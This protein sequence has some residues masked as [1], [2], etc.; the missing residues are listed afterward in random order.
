[1]IQERTDWPRLPQNPDGLWQWC[2]EQDLNTL[3]TLLAYCAARTVNAIKSKTNIDGSDRLNHSN[4]LGTA[5]HLNMT[6]WFQPTAENFVDRI[7]KA[8][9]S[10]AMTEAGRSPDSTK[11]AMKKVQFAK[12]AELEI[13]GTGWLP[14]PL[15]IS[16]GLADENG[17]TLK[18]VQPK[19]IPLK[20][21]KKKWRRDERPF[22]H[23]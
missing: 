12:V 1:M 16:A 22:P 19:K 23:P 18:R 15:R 17:S 9:I 13:A 10:E 4:A 21:M 8:C 20:L 5:L 2:L 14:Q 6:R 11:L 7:S 3:L